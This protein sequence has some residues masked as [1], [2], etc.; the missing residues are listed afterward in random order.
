MNYL[1]TLST[2]ISAPIGRLLIATIFLMSGINKIF[3]YA[4]TVG[5]ME[6]MGVSGSLL[7]LVI[8]TEVIGGI[9]IILGWHTRLAAFFLA[10]F[11]L[12]AALI[13]HFD[14]ANQMQMIMFM[15]NM[16]IIGAFLL[17]IHNGAGAFSIDQYKARNR[18]HD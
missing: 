3:S 17:L 9:A 6:A 12:L 11:T 14:F 2:Q 10:G 16:A 15:K 4:G 8:L 1:I 18:N 13:F 5:Y 7:P